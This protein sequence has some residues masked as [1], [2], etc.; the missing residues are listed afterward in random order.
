MIKSFI[1]SLSF[2]SVSLIDNKSC[3]CGSFEVGIIKYEVEE[4]S[5]CCSGKF[6]HSQGSIG[7]YDNSEGAWILVD[8][9]KIDNESITIACC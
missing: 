1:F 2:L 7:L 3:N 9:K 4:G 8:V 6:A 5:S